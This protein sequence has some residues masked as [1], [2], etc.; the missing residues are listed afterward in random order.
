M[1][2]KDL[3]KEE[4]AEQQWG[5][6]NVLMDSRDMQ[7]KF[8]NRVAKNPEEDEERKQKVEELQTKLIGLIKEK[9]NSCLTKRQKDVIDLYLVSKKQEHMGKI[10]GI[11]Q[12]AVFSRLNLAFK[13]L[14]QACNKDTKIQEL[15][16]E[17][18]RI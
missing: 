12:E 2:K 6:I 17:I 5:Y 4:Y 15:L 8:E 1:G 7:N 3:T 18:K 11:T 16:K 14:K 13:R 10:L 9:F